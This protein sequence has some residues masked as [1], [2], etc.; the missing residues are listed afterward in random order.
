ML[1][2]FA[3]IHTLIVV[4]TVRMS[5]RNMAGVEGIEPPS[6]VLET[7]ILPLN[8]T[9]NVVLPGRIELPSEVPQT[10]ILSVK[11]QEQL[12]AIFYHVSLFNVFVGYM[13][14]SQY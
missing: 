7:S 6:K 11:L 10:S 1:M 5:S 9:P 3:V 13:R 12:A 8:Y 14:L 2:V 4:R